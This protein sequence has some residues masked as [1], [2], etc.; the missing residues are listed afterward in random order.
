VRKKYPVLFWLLVAIL[1]LGISIFLL[2]RNRDV[3]ATITVDGIP[4]D[5]IVHL[6]PTYDESTALPVVLVLHGGGSSGRRIARFTGFNEVADREGIIAVYPDG[7]DNSWADGRGVTGAE[8]ASIDDVAFISAL[9]DELESV[10]AVDTDRV[11]LAGISNGGFMVQTL[12]CNLSERIQ[13]G[14]SLLLP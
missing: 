9:L 2:F 14:R 11:Y 13:A 5:Y 12:V 3:K 8:Q 1:L 10:Y 4:R 7:Y 6:P